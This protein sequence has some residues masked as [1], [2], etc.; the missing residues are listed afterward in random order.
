MSGT[1]Q[2]GN[3]PALTRCKG[4]QEVA[5]PNTRV[6]RGF[7][8]PDRA[9]HQNM[10]PWSEDFVSAQLEAGYDPLRPVLLRPG[11]LGPDLLRPSQL[12]CVEVCCV[13]V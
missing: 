13:C 5:D 12:W 4:Q 6:W 2:G 7:E 10:E 8:F 11:K 9:G 1:V 3:L